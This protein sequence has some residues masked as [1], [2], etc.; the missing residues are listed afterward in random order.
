MKTK[1]S[2]SKKRA[3]V[4]GEPVVRGVLEATLAELADVGYGALRIEEVAARAGVNKTTIYRRWPTKPELVQAALLSITVDRVIT[5]NTGSLRGD[6]LAIGRDIAMHASSA[7]GQ[8]MRRMLIAEERNPELMAIDRSIFASVQA[9]P[10]PII[11]A[12]KARGELAPGV[13]GMM[14][15]TILAST[16]H[17]RLL[18]ERLEV[19]DAYITQLVDLV[20]VGAL[21]PDKRKKDPDGGPPQRRRP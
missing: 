1:R 6:L 4:R 16:I 15:V 12:A 13:D 14:L 3:L 19:D 11:E 21:S 2:S 5:P 9:A 20:L 7:E 8:S 17:H 10:R 18:L